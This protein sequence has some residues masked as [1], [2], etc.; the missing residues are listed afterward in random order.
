MMT[1]RLTTLPLAHACRVII[2]EYSSSWHHWL[3]YHCAVTPCV[4]KPV[5]PCPQTCSRNFLFV[6]LHFA[7]G[8]LFSRIRPLPSATLDLLHHQHTEESNL[9]LEVIASCELSSMHKALLIANTIN[10]RCMFG[11]AV[12][13]SY[14]SSTAFRY[15]GTETK[16]AGGYTT[17]WYSFLKLWYNEA[18]LCIS[19]GALNNQLPRPKYIA[20]AGWYT[21]CSHEVRVWSQASMN[22]NSTIHDWSNHKNMHCMRLYHAAHYCNI[23]N[24]ASWTNHMLISWSMNLRK[25]VKPRTQDSQRKSL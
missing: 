19:L 6:L 13:H 12:I 24:L 17:G 15:F 14:T 11:Y 4:C 23:C 10:V 20:L 3:S 22:W 18:L 8:H 5:S 21:A 9:V 16:M 25:A 1:D 7:N 2:Q